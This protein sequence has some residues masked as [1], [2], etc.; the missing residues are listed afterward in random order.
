VNNDP[1]FFS[2]G[3]KADIKPKPVDSTAVV[4]LKEIEESKKSN[5]SAWNTSG[6]W[7]ERK[8][9]IKI[10]MDAL[11]NKLLNLPIAGGAA[12]IVKINKCDGDAK[13][14]LSRGKKRLGYTLAI[15]YNYEATGKDSSS[16]GTI[17]FK[18]LQ[19][20][21]DYEVDVEPSEESEVGDKIQSSVKAIA[22]L[23]YTTINN[24]KD[25]Y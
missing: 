17:S 18:E 9:E 6:T 10:I 11:E 23:T 3:T 4:K 2:N 24:I 7:E 1:N 16:T 15:Q 19:D 13:L 22:E 12:K 25:S 14:I 21:G 8:I 5:H 20:D